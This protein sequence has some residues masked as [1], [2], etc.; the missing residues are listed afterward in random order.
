MKHCGKQQGV[1]LIEMM[2][3]MM[4]SLVLIAGVGT[5]YVSSKRTYQTRDQL[6]N[7]DETARIA[8][9]ALTKHLEHAGYA[10]AD[11]LPIG[12]YM[13]YNGAADPN[14]IPC[15][16]DNSIKSVSGLKSRAT[17]NAFNAYGD[18]IAVRFIGD[19][20]IFNDC[21]NGQLPAACRADAAPSS[22][23]A[24]IYNSF[25]VDKDSKNMFNLY[26]MGS[27]NDKAK[28]LVNGVENIQ[29][30]YG[31]D[32]NADGAVDRYVNAS[33]VGTDHWQHV[34]SIQ[35]AILVRSS[36][37]VPEVETAQSYSLLDATVSMTD[38]YKRAVYTTVIQ[39]RN[40]VEG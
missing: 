3:A 6:S 34:V 19:N 35:V 5:V 2:I 16:G 15:G 23:A 12:D 10:T 13:Y 38:R 21:A 25:Y 29:F 37:E 8:L 22:Q 27:R 20:T 14:S 36:S 28:P 32:A 1:T 31:V 26:C 33:N 24:L 17:K 9:D 18:A 30:M 39:L 40:A 11:K 4:V 7:M